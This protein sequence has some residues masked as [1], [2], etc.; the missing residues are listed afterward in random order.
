MKTCKKCSEEK[1]IT[2][3]YKRDS[4]KD[5]HSTMCKSCYKARASAWSS[6][7][8]EK[9]RV[10]VRE[11]QKRYRQDPEKRKKMDCRD[12]LNYQ[13]RHNRLKRRGICEMCY[14]VGTQCHHWDYDKPLEYI[15]L[16][17][18]CHSHLHNNSTQ[19]ANTV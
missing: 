11:A 1:A 5:G 8:R 12:R 10:I 7:N 18:K 3:F 16:C 2:E 4:G 17:R 13:F 9:R 19:H 14:D 15:E 6:R